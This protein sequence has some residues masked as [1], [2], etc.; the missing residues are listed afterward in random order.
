MPR[1]PMR[2]FPIRRPLAV[3]PQVQPKREEG[4][5]FPFLGYIVAGV[6]I[7]V[8]LV[9][10][11]TQLGGGEGVGAFEK[12]LKKDLSSASLTGAV[13]KSYEL[14]S[15]YGEICFVDLENINMLDIVDKPTIKSSVV[16][17]IGNNVFLFGREEFKSF[18][19]E[20]IKVSSYPYYNCV[21]GISGKI[22]IS[23]QE[24]NGEVIVKLLPNSNFCRNAQNKRLDDGS[25][26]CGYLDSLF[27]EGYKEECC[28][29]YGYCC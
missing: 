29:N 25:N 10:I 14:P 16:A 22:E 21:K 7:I 19:I 23:A 20:D 12:D 17:G 2:R 1:Y 3:N 11:F 24:R 9:L 13:T 5:H 27:F 28:E 26:L 4:V 18:Y 8:L 15:G 6:V